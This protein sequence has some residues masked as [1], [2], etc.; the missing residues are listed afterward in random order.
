MTS[1]LPLLIPIAMVATLAVLAVGV[2]GMFRG[3]SF[4][5]KY[6]NKLMQARVLLQAVAIA[7]IALFLFLTHR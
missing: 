5:K 6:G 7:L 1:I 3:G 2:F 4:N